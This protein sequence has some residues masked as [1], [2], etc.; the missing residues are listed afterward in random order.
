[1]TTFFLIRHGSNDYFTHTLVG[2]K[3]GVHLNDAGRSEADRLAARLSNEGIQ[4]IF[5]SPLER[6][7]E[8]AE[9]LA[10]KIGVKVQTAGE[11]LEVD[12]GDWTGKTF[13]ELDTLEQWKQWNY[14]RSGGRA[15]NGETMIEVQSRI[16][17]LIQRLHREH[18]NGR[19]ALF[20]HGDPLRAALIYFLGTSLEFIRRIELSPASTSILELTD[21]DVKVRCMNSLP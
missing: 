8:T 16:V 15:G 21:W 14:F 19:I 5:S 12:F 18:P 2:R 1:M 6:C 4:T 10:S 9:P 13:A 7:R 3:P 20:S 11:L 17:G